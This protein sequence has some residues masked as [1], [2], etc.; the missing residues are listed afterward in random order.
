MASSVNPMR[1]SSIGWLMNQRLELLRAPFPLL[2]Q[3]LEHRRHPARIDPRPHHVDHPDGVGLVLRIA[4]ELGEHRALAGVDPDARGLRARARE[5]ARE[6]R[7]DLRDLPLLLQL[8]RVPLRDV[9]DLVTDH[10]RELIQ[11]VRAL[12]EPAVHEHVPARQREGVDLGAVHDVEM[13]FEIARIRH[14]GERI[15]EHRDV[16][17]DVGVGDH[18]Q[19]VRHLCGLLLAL[20][21][22]A[23]RG[24]GAARGRAGGDD[25]RGRE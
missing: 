6:P 9:A 21:H 10:A 23:R 24:G 4:A 5:D 18:R 25:R 8:H 15:A 3:L 20:L 11:A 7:A 13:P 14:G 19:G 22:F 17:V 2:Q 1:S 12:D 16:A